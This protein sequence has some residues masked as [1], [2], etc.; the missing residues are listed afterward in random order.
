MKLSFQAVRPGGAAKPGLRS[1][2]GLTGH[3]G[4]SSGCVALFCS[5]ES[6][7]RPLSRSVCTDG[8]LL[9]LRVRQE[10]CGCEVVV[11]RV[12]SHKFQVGHLAG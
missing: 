11:E 6:H 1:E 2:D 12:V 9:D 5:S 3:V 10:E 4:T 8:N 7:L